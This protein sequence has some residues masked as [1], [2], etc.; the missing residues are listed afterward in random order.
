MRYTSRLSSPSLT[1]SRVCSL[2]PG[3]INASATSA[4]QRGSSISDLEIWMQSAVHLPPPA[5]A[6]YA[7]KMRQEGYEEL[8]F[9]RDLGEE[10]LDDVIGAAGMKKGHAAQFKRQLAD[11]VR[12][13]PICTR[14]RP[15][16]LLTVCRRRGTPR[17]SDCASYT[18]T[19]S[20]TLSSE[21]WW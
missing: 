17:R 13:R 15:S 8:G 7:E 4:L 1:S 21:S 12:H 10:D 2:S 18:R 6:G 9:L 3:V 5:A 11:E 19:S 14:L 16:E 20:M